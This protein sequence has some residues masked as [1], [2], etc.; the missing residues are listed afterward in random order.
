[1]IWVVLGIALVLIAL[2]ALVVALRRRR[3]DGVADFQRHIGALSSEAR[4][5]V[6]DQ[7]HQLDDSDDSDD[8]D[9]EERPPPERDA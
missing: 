4:R 8:S 2:V 5:P 9:D 3:S 6:V 1:V 7:V